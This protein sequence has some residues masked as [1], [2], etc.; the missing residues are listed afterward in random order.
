MASKNIEMHRR[1]E[2][3]DEMRGVVMYYLQWGPWYMDSIS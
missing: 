2:Q 3:S 1:I